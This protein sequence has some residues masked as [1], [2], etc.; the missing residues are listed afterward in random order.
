MLAGSKLVAFLA[1]ADGDKARD[2]YEN[3]LGFRFIS[4]DAAALVFDAGGTQLRIQKVRIVVPQPHTALGWSVT[5]IEKAIDDLQ[6]RGVI[7][8]RYSFLEQDARGIW[9]SPSG[10]KVAWLKDPDRNL[11]SLTEG[12][13]N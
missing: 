1:T 9:T 2:F 3:G 13:R 10:A 11:L 12:P 8:E 7:F 4:E 6:A 5:S